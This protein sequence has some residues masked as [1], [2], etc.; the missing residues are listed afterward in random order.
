M[1][2]LLIL[3]M[4]MLIGCTDS[5]EA[6]RVLQMNGYTD[7]KITGYKFFGC[8]NS[9]DFSTGFTAKNSNNIIV[10]GVVCSSLYSKGSTIRF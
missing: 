9:D 10:T 4:F 8:S 3:F 5:S 2:K 1:K 7:I 6:I